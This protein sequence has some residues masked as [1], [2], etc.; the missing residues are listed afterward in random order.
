M[1]KQLITI[2]T[3]IKMK[4]CFTVLC[5]V[6][7][8]SC[9]QVVGFDYQA[10]RKICLNCILNPDSIV[11]VDLYYTRTLDET[12]EFEPV[13]NATLEFFENGEPWGTA[14]PVSEGN[15][16]L[17]KK[18]LEGKTYAVKCTAPGNL[19]LTA[20]TTVQE[21]PDVAYVV[22]SRKKYERWQ[23]GS[24]SSHFYWLLVDYQLKDQNGKDFYW[25]YTLGWYSPYKKYNYGERVSYISPY[26]DDFNRV[27]DP[28]SKNG[29]YY[30]L[31]ARLTDAGVDGEQLTFTK[32]MTT[33]KI[34]VFFNADEHYDRYMK[35]SVQLWL[36]E[37]W[38]ELPFKEPVQIYSNIENGTGIFG[39]ASFIYLSFR[40]E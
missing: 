23:E 32:D 18:P 15:Y 39:S 20:E 8:L 10:E 13:T 5:S 21:K 16:Q 36:I 11:R 30:K 40:N 12:G 38:E 35:S 28:E 19:P 31:Y 22:Q 1:N 37:E 3:L 9:E 6:V 7:L 26:I 14:N 25:N 29:F 17:N 27:V 34:D 33:K 4:V 24:E 2:Y